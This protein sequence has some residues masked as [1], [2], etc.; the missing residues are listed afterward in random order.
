MNQYQQQHSLLCLPDL[1]H[2]INMHLFYLG[3]LH[4]YI[5]VKSLLIPFQGLPYV[6]R[7]VPWMFF[8]AYMLT[9]NCLTVS[10]YLA[11][12]RPHVYMHMNVK[13]RMRLSLIVVWL[14]A[15]LQ[16]V[17][18]VMVLASLSGHPQARSRLF[19]IS[20]VGAR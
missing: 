19:L 5:H 14:L 13:L 11:S 15:S 18:P 3:L 4:S 10:Q 9:L 20:K 16:I 7:S 1:S 6:F 17:I 12:C 2:M 8:T